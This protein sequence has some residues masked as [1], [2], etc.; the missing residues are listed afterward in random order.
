MDEIHF[1]CVDDI[2]ILG[3]WSARVA[4]MCMWLAWSAVPAQQHMRPGGAWQNPKHREVVLP[5]FQRDS[6]RARKTSRRRRVSN[7]N[8]FISPRQGISQRSPETTTNQYADAPLAS[9]PNSRL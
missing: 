9:N 7:P 1:V 8:K 4:L 6:G 3:H 2:I 5:E